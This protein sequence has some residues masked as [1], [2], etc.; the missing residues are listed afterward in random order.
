MPA[1]RAIR[2]EVACR[3]RHGAP[4]ELIDGEI[5]GD[6][7]AIETPFI[8]QDFGQQFTVGGAGHAIDFVVT[9]HHR[10]EARFLDCGLEG[11][12]EDLS[13]FPGWGYG[14]GSS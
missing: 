14:R 2:A 1:S 10:I 4:S 13:Q 3:G 7:D 12:Q 11:Q 8:T 9:I 6:D 5:I